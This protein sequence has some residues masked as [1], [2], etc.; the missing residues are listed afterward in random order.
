MWP[1]K[2]I[3]YN[4]K[5]FHLQLEEEE[6]FATFIRDSTLV[7]PSY[8][9]LKH[10]L[11]EPEVFILLYLSFDF[12]ALV[13]SADEDHAVYVFEIARRIADVT[14]QVY[15]YKFEIIPFANGRRRRF[16]RFH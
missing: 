1:I 9:T 14:N 13:F 6:D 8:W 2:Y 16:Y 11:N 15:N 3:T 10:L 4:F 5:I 12:N 7:E